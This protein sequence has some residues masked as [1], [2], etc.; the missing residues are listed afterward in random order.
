MGS[1]QRH[2]AA[3]TVF[4]LEELKWQNPNMPFY[5]VTFPFIRQVVGPVDYTQGAYINASK[6]GF[7]IDYHKPMSQGTRA[8]QVASYIVYDSPLVMLCD[9]P[10]RYLSDIPCTEY[11]ASIPT[12]FDHTIILYGKIGEYIV[13]AREKE[14]V[15]YIGGITN[16]DDRKI[17]ISL[18]FLQE[19][20]KYLV[21]ELSDSDDSSNSP[22][23]Y[24][25]KQYEVDNTS[26]VVLNMA[27]GGGSALIIK[28]NK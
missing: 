15:W 19:G 11:I 20:N 1:L 16:W 25:I 24:T 22:E 23:K 26:E 7:R 9:S 14:G 13:T 10:S 5:D 28:K 18:S 3:T 21:S 27:M 6:E 2:R 12:V 8:H 4:G 17:T